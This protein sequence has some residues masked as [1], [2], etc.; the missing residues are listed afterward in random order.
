MFFSKLVPLKIKS[1]CVSICLNYLQLRLSAQYSSVTPDN[2]VAGYFA[3]MACTT[4]VSEK[5]GYLAVLPGG[6][7]L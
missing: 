6:A 5:A 4:N 1:Q 3:I 7:T 2:A